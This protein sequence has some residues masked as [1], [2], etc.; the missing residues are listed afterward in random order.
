MIDKPAHE[1]AADNVGM[2]LRWTSHPMK[3]RPLATLLLS[4]FILLVSFFIYLATESSWFSLLG[5]VVLYVS[6][7][8]FYWPTHYHLTDRDVTVK[9]SMQTVTKEWSAYRSCYPDKN[10]I[11]LSPFMKPSRLENF[12][13]IF[14]MFE[15]NKDE[16][17]TF[18]RQ[19][20]DRQ[21]E[22][23]LSDSMEGGG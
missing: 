5:L 3:R 17:V 11:L 13:G 2:Q 10:G 12:R 8:R 7:A 22:A 21:R 4:L 18:V 14:L 15:N 23:V 1:Q 9:T 16:V 19:Q 6:T 20:I